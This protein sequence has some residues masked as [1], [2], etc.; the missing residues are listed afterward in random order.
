ERISSV[1]QLRRTGPARMKTKT[2]LITGAASGIGLA[3]AKRLARTGHDLFLVDRNKGVRETADDL[4]DDGISAYSAV[5]DVADE[6]Q[7]VEVAR[8]AIEKL[9]GCSIV[10][11]CAGISPK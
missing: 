10:V 11:N 9:Q 5:A 7:L 1:Y 3:L 8:N 2:A 4:E 6:R